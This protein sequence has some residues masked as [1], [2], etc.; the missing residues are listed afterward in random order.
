MKEMFISSN[1]AMDLNSQS[2]MYEVRNFPS[3]TKKAFIVLMGIKG[4]LRHQPML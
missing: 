3:C 2:K 1:W 4:L